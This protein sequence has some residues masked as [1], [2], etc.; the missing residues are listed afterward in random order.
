[1]PSSLLTLL[2]HQNPLSLGSSETPKKET[3]ANL[4]LAYLCVKQASLS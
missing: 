2:T 1:M 3:E 4:M